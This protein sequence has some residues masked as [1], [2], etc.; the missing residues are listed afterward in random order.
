MNEKDLQ[1]I[2][3]M[4]ESV[5]GIVPLHLDSFTDDAH[6]ALSTKGDR[7]MK[8]R[9]RVCVDYSDNGAPV[10]KQI[11]GG[12]EMELADRI[13]ETILNSP[14]R[15][16]FLQRCGIITEA[17]PAAPQMTFE[18]YAQKWVDSNVRIIANTRSTYKKVLHAHINPCFGKMKLADIQ[19]NDVLMFLSGLAE[20]DCSKSL[21]NACLS[22]LRQILQCAV[23]HCSYLSGELSKANITSLN[24]EQ[25]N[26]MPLGTCQHLV[27]LVFCSLCFQ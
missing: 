13:V 4:I 6:N 19:L 5:Y 7:A 8:K 12:S 18:E 9:F 22:I 24:K 15:N 1:G 20:D 25:E 14:R 11:S 3:N 21:G 16:E 17:A 2:R 10:V 27:L 23:S 26:H